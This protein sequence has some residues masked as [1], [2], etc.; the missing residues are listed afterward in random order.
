MSQTDSFIDEVSEEV[1]RDRTYTLIRRYGWIAVVVVI[2]IVGGAAWNEWRKAREASLAQAAGDALATA[3]EIEDPAERQNALLDSD[4]PESAAPVAELLASA[5]ALAA[6]T[7]DEAADILAEL[8]ADGSADAIYSDLAGYKLLLT[9]PEGYLSDA[10]RAAMFERLSAP[11]APYR[12]L[13]LEQ[14]VVELAAAGETGAALDGAQALLQENGLTA[15]LRQRVSQL[16]VAL[17]GDPNGTAGAEDRAETTP[18]APAA[19][20]AR[21]AE[22]AAAPAADAG[23][24]VAPDSA[25][26]ETGTE[27]AAAPAAAP[28]STTP[29]AAPEDTDAAPA[30]TNDT[31]ADQG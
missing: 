8:A 9:A 22:P 4:V 7:P 20:T 12:L 2:L 26:P 18:S 15:G 1:R 3:Q 30:E 6:D 31:E 17:G 27:P 25:A 10:D 21:V 5:A 23:A 28:E 16:I 24:E 11:G 14:K 13:A 19:P 29:P